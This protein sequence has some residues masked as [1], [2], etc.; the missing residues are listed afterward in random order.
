MTEAGTGWLT[1]AA[2]ALLTGAT[3]RR[4][5]ADAGQIGAQAAA[6]SATLPGLVEGFLDAAARAA[7]TALAHLPQPTWRSR[8]RR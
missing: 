7:L 3:G 2:H 4:R 6:A 8:S 5:L 1:A